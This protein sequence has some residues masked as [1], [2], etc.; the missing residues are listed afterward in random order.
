MAFLVWK[1]IGGKKRLVIRWNRRVNGKPKVVKE[2]YIGDMENLARI[3][4][5]PE[6]NV[7]A[8]SQSFGVTAAVLLVERDMH[9]R[10]TVDSIIGHRNNGL[11]PGDYTLIFIM[12]R[13][14]D[15]RSKNGIGEWM[16]GDYASTLYPA[17]TS[18]GFWNMMDRFSE[19]GMKAIKERIRERLISL[20][21]DH[22]RLFVDGSNF[23]TFMKENDIAK[24][25]HSKQ[26]RY[27][28]N[29]IAYY[30]AANEDYIPFYGDA[31]PGNM[32]DSDTFPW[33]AEN[34]PPDSTVIFDRGYN[35]EKNVSLLGKRKYIGALVLSDHKDLVSLPLARDSFTETSKI[36]YGKDHRII[37][38]HST[39]LERKQ[40]MA[41]MRRF[42]KAYRHV[43][44]IMQS[45]DSDSSQKALYY[46]ESMHLQE[47]ILLPDLRIDSSRMARRFSMMG[48]NALFTNIMDMGAESIIDLY[49]KRNRVEH[50]FRTISMSD[51][52]KPEYHWTPQKIRVHMFFSLMA[53]L[54]LALIRY[55][56]HSIDQS[57]SLQSV[58]DKLSDVRL[59]YI[60]SGKSVRKK[61]DSRNP[62]ALRM[63]ERLDLMSV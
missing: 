35:S 59:Q 34:I 32:H 48:K 57:T 49:R 33:I 62:D 56:M 16:R 23:F 50:C 17:V 36:V 25:G 40:T 15:P 21:Y 38:Y 39:R 22:S 47:T 9:L 11:S 27:D 8:Y 63:A 54:F 42:T 13:L 29:Q 30:I 10:D 28:L 31:Y 44:K 41:F 3:I 46:L 5:H 51:L 55:R 43:S 45:G 18:Q 7:D 4:E 61:L 60:I 58:H 37:M 2:V 24:K 6:E 1:T 53:Y 12:N 26:H 19:E 52:A 14:S 20:G